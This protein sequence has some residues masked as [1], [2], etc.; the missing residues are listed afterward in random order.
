MNSSLKNI[1]V[2]L[3]ILTFAFVGYYIFVQDNNSQIDS[4]S[5]TTV[6]DEMLAKTSLFIERRAILDS[7]TLDTT[8]FEDPL[9]VSYRNFTLPVFEQPIGKTN[10]FLEKNESNEDNF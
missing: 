10:P 8:V 6:T 7:I 9:F 3:V 4:I 5:D 1:I 2:L